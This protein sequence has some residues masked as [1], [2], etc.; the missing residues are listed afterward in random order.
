MRNVEPRVK[1]RTG[2]TLHAVIGPK[3]LSTVSCL[4]RIGER[5]QPMRAGKR[6]VAGRVPVLR[7]YDVIETG[8]ECVDARD[9]LLSAGDRKGTAGEEVTLHVDDQK[10]GVG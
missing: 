2:R 8:S 9:D 10:S 4:D 6:D 1:L 3:V 7:Q 5:L